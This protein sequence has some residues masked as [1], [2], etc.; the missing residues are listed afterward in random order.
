MNSLIDTPEAESLREAFYFLAGHTPKGES[1]VSEASLRS[2]LADGFPGLTRENVDSGIKFLREIRRRI[3]GRSDNQLFLQR[4][5]LDLLEAMS[6]TEERIGTRS[7]TGEVIFFNLGKFSQLRH[8]RKWCKLVFW[9]DSSAR[10][11]WRKPTGMIYAAN[12]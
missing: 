2:S 7:R 5:F 8:F 3:T 4:V 11:R 10:K 12:F 6:I 1:S 9:R